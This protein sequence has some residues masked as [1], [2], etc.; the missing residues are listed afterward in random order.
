VSL[1]CVEI[2][3]VRAIR[4]GRQKTAWLRAIDSE[5]AMRIE[6]SKPRERTRVV[7]RDTVN[8]RI[9]VVESKL[10]GREYLTV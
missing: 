2:Q 3:V 5:R 8:E 4:G 9:T 7:E 1:S 6:R 10:S